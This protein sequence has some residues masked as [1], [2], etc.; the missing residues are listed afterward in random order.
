MQLVDRLLRK[1]NMLLQLWLK[2]SYYSPT[3]E[4]NVVVS[5]QAEISLELK[6]PKVAFYWMLLRSCSENV[7]I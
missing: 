5:W 2:I 7:S 3:C 6:A 4:E 1:I